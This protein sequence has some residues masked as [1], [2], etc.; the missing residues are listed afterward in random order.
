[1]PR[2]CTPVPFFVPTIPTCVI[3]R[4]RC[5]RRTW[6]SFSGFYE[7]YFSTGELPREML[8]EKV[9]VHDHD[10]PD[11]GAYRELPALNAGFGTGMTPGPSGASSQRS[12]LTPTTAW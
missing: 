6:L 2:V 8:D 4:G 12:S 3:L 9:E 5:R 1:M 7:R 10:T 11:Q